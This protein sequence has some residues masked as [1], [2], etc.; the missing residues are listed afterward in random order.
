MELVELAAAGNEASDLLRVVDAGLLRELGARRAYW[1]VLDEG[2]V[3][4]C[5]ALIV[6]RSDGSW[7]AQHVEA[8]AGAHA[9]RTEDAE[10]LAR[11][12]GWVYVLGSH[13]GSKAGPLR[14]KRAFVAR[15]RESARPELEIVRHRFALHRAIN[16]ALAELVAT[17]HPVAPGAVDPAVHDGFIE[18]TLRRGTARGK[19]WV[20]QLAAGDHPVNIEGAAFTGRGT[21]LVGLRWPVTAAGEP[22]LVELAGVPGLFDG[23]AVRVAGVYALTGTGAGPLGVRALAA[24]PDGAYDAVVG[25]ID[26]LDKGSVLLERHPHARHATCRHVRFELPGQPGPALLR[27][28]PVAD[29][30][31]LHHVE[32]VSERDGRPIYVTDEDHRIGLWL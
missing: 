22:V 10:A 20:A 1:T 28:E 16:D 30:A 23:G 8:E 6:E 5:L 14:P 11:H 27:A 17:G 2:P 31:P 21:L 3:E 15:F 25:S 18:Q 7:H 13:F 4:R 26:A 9:G 12:D 24:R 29:L 32:G 19:A